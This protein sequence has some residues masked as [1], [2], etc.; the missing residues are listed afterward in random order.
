MVTDYYT[1]I[2]LFICLFV[3]LDEQGYLNLKSLVG[4]VI[5]CKPWVVQGILCRK[6][7]IWV[8]LQ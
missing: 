6:S 4:M 8:Q 7:C 2:Y 3:S 1:L 5:F